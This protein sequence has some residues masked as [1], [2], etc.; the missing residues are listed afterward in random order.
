MGDTRSGMTAAVGPTTAAAVGL[1]KAVIPVGLG[2]DSLQPA[3]HAVPLEMLPVVDKPLVQYAVEEA[4]ACGFDELIFLTQ[5]GLAIVEDHF[6]PGGE[7]GG[8]AA[9][10]VIGRPSAWGPAG[11]P[12]QVVICRQGESQGLGHALWTARNLIGEE[13]F[14]VLIPSDML[15][16]EKLGM[17]Q[18]IDH[19]RERK[20]NVVAVS[21]NGLFEREGSFAAIAAGS[22]GRY[23]LQPD[24]FPAL[25]RQQGLDIRQ[26][27][28]SMTEVWP[29]RALA[30][31]GHHFDCR[32][33]EGL[34]E[35]QVAFALDRGDL[36]GHMDD[37]LARYG[38]SRNAGTGTNRAANAWQSGD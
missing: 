23:I 2:D 22:A 9:T 7:D 8:A 20:G 35:A 36:A 34:L 30:F 32:S 12:R 1:R 38:N 14:A 17:S 25:A 4:L 16:G 15:L 26:A 10:R 29:S 21:D 28:L 37:V 31:A 5:Q 33:P 19:Y 18:L 24:V 27:I 6:A 3:S 13:A 11:R